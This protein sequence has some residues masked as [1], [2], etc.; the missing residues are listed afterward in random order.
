VAEA[1]V[2]QAV[3]VSVHE[4]ECFWPDMGFGAGEDR[5]LWMILAGVDGG[6]IEAEAVAGGLWA[7]GKAGQ[8]EGEGGF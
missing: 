3:G 8:G 7:V 2:F 4:V 1:R 6:G 5:R